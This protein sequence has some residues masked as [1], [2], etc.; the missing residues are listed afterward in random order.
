M[1]RRAF[2]P[3]DD[4]IM[5]EMRAAGASWRAVALKLGKSHLGCRRHWVTK[6][7]GKAGWARPRSIRAR[8]AL[9]TETRQQASALRGS[10]ASREP[11]PAGNSVTWEAITQ[12][13]VLHGR[14]YKQQQPASF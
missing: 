12:G 7:Q 8:A 11:L 10:V 6:L 5:I 4:A 13:T 1:R 2:T 14:P 3:T 9:P